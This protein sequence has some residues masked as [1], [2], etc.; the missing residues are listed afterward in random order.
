MS[1]Y[2]LDSDLQLG[3]TDEEFIQGIRDELGNTEDGCFSI[4]T[5]ENTVGDTND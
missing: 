1:D 2:G 4:S 3:G 5:I